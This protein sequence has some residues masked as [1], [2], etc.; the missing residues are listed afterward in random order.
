M[1]D[2]EETE[3]EAFKDFLI[4]C[5]VSSLKEYETSCS[6]EDAR[7]V[8]ERKNALIQLLEKGKAE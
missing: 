3:S 6:N 7:R 4:K 1:K 5:G 8:S 2:M